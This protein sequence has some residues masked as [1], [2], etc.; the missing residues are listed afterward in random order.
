MAPVGVLAASYL[1]LNL[2]GQLSTRWLLKG[3]PKWQV[4]ASGVFVG[5]DVGGVPRA[6]G[7]GVTPLGGPLTQEA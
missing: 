7:A 6:A 3:Y 4:L 1:W 5:G 2:A